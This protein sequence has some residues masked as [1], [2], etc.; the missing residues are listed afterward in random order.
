[1]RNRLGRLG[2]GAQF[3]GDARARKRF[4]VRDGVLGPEP[5]GLDSIAHGFVSL[6]AGFAVDESDAAARHRV[7]FGTI[8]SR[9]RLGHRAFT[10]FGAPVKRIPLRRKML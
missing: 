5:H 8:L 10:P 4:A 2:V 7:L 9:R 1:M 3:L 6:R